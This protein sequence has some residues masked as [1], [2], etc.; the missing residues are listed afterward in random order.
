MIDALPNG[1]YQ[2]GL[3]S[4]GFLLPVNKVA[5]INAFTPVCHSFHR[6]MG[7]RSL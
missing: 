1:P 2:L 6:G 3:N 5:G 4:E 7:C